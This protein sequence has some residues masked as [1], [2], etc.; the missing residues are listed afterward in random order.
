MGSPATISSPVECVLY[1]C[2]DVYVSFTEV[3]Y[4]FITVP[5]T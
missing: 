1:D 5:G 4:I 3:S 2:K